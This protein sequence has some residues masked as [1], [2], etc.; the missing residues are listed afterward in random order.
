MRLYGVGVGPGDPELIAL[1]ALRVIKESD[2]VVVPYTSRMLTY[3]AVKEY[4]KDKEVILFNL[5]IRGSRED[6]KKLASQ[7]SRYE[8]V[9]YVTLGDPAF[10]SSFYRLTEFVEPYEVI[11]GVTSFSWCSALH[12]IPVA[13][14]K[15]NVLITTDHQP[16]YV[17][18]V[19]I[20]KRNEKIGAYCGNDY[21]TVSILKKRFRVLER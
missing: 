6:Y 13:L 21:F 3:N 1:K 15:E 11:P 20:M 17:D 18:K 8:K 2:V 19:I 16:T 12:R 5:P 10:Y 9:A 14:G 4:L 7:V